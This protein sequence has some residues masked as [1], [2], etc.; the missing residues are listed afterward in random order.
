MWSRTLI[1]SL[2][3][4][5]ALQ[6]EAKA[7]VLCTSGTSS[8]SSVGAIGPDPKS[9]AAF[10]PS[11][12]LYT[13]DIKS[14]G[15]YFSRSICTSAYSADYQ[16]QLASL[17]IRVVMKRKGRVYATCVIPDGQL[18]DG[19]LIPCSH[20]TTSYSLGWFPVGVPVGSTYFDWKR[21]CKAPNGRVTVPQLRIGDSVELVEGKGHI[22][23]TAHCR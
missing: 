11:L 13:S 14:K 1:L 8:K 21:Y 2:L 9:G 19:T 20:S 7:Q 15:K 4:F 23:A 3:V 10:N 18:S 5:A 22:V 17:R 12:F 6:A 16:H